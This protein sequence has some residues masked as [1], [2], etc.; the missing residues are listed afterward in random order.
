[1]EPVTTA[2]LRPGEARSV[3]T[4]N[5]EIVFAPVTT[6]RLCIKCGLPIS[7][8]FNEFPVV[9]DRKTMNVIAVFFAH[10]STEA[11]EDEK[12]ARM[13][14][15]DPHAFTT[16][17][18]QMLDQFVTTLKAARADQALSKERRKDHPGPSAETVAKRRGRK[19]A[20]ANT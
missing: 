8:G 14:D 19:P 16:I 20:Y 9:D 5:G 3:V 15:A 6:A 2:G 12:A 1:M 7:F 10:P 18:A 11:C 13:P 4:N 17:R